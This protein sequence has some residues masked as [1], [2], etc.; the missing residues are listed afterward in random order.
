MKYAIVS[1]ATVAGW[2]ALALWY[3]K[4]TRPRLLK[5]SGTVAHFTK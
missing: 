1:L 2:I 4:H 5:G 3:E